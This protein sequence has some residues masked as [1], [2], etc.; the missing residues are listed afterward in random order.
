MHTFTKKQLIEFVA[1]L[2][3]DVF[4]IELSS[5]ASSFKRDKNKTLIP[6]YSEVTINLNVVL[7][8]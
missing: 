4:E 7:A 3:S 5:S 1:S 6:V 8:N 2:D